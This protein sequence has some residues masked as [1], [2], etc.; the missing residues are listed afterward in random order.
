MPRLPVDGKKVIE[1]RVTLG[2]YEREQVN[3]FVDGVQIRNIG[4]GIGAATDPI[5]AMLSNTLGTIGG[6]FLVSWALK[7]FF[8]IDVP[9]P[10]DLE[11]ISEGWNAIY[12]TIS[13]ISDETRQEIDDYI[14][15][16]DLKEKAELLSPF[17]A[18]IP[19]FPLLQFSTRILKGA[20]DFI[21]TPLDNPRFNPNYG[22]ISADYVDPGLA[23]QGGAGAPAPPGGGGS[24]GPPADNNPFGLSSEQ[25]DCVLEK[26]NL[27]NAGDPVYRFEQNVI[28]GMVQICGL[29]PAQAGNVFK[30]FR[31]GDPF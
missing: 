5:E 9:I 29:T 30:A 23:N 7:R 1:Y 4:T 6:V 11:D 27:H 31:D 20:A 15:K 14:D 26:L 25:R 12:N 2:T 10:T 8:N 22:D 18:L 3:R 16:I 28:Q 13:N 17:A 24:S 19:G 21:F